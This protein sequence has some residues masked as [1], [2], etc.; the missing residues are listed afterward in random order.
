MK[1]PTRQRS[2]AG[3]SGRRH[4]AAGFP[5]YRTRPIEVTAVRWTGEDNCEE[6]F[7]FLGWDHPDDEIEHTL[8]VGLGADGKQE[9]TPGDW[10]IHDDGIYEVFTDIAFRAEFE[11]AGDD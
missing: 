4:P 11:A 8:I 9:A 6:V 5:R 7:A 3:D 2:V 1:A 10:I